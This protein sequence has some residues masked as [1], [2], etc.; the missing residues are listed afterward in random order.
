LLRPRADVFFDLL[1]IMPPRIADSAPNV[2]PVVQAI[3]IMSD[4]SSLAYPDAHDI[5]SEGT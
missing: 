3:V 2:D 1:L 4:S 5:H